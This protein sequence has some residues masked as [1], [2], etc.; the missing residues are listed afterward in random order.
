MV[1]CWNESWDH[2]K[3]HKG[4]PSTDTDS[5]SSQGTSV[6]LTRWVNA[7]RGVAQ[8]FPAKNIPIN[9]LGRDNI[10]WKINIKCICISG[11]G[12][13]IDVSY[14]WLPVITCIR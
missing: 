10:D 11:G 9:R 3:N 8:V 14:G 5:G 2:N 12:K 13:V 7:V 1:S 4:W 6:R